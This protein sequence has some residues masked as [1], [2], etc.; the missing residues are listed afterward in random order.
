MTT[1]A[2]VTTLLSLALFGGFVGIGVR[3]FSLLPSYSAYASKWK[4]AVPINRETNLWGIVTVATALLLAPALI[5]K[6]SGNPLQ[7]LGFF[8]PVYLAVVAFTPDFET[9]RRQLRFHVIGTA[10]CAAVSLAWII[11]VCHTWWTLPLTFFAAWCVAYATLSVK[12]CWLFW[13]E[14]AMFAAVYVSLLIP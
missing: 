12:R 1:F 2:I 8:A 6:A 4:E 7:C 13:C 5:E 9:N 14:M 11:F 10:L 3:K